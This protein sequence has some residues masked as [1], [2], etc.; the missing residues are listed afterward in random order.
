MA[1]VDSGKKLEQSMNIDLTDQCSC[2]S[3][4]PEDLGEQFAKPWALVVANMGAGFTEQR[5]NAY[6][7][8]YG[9]TA[10]RNFICRRHHGDGCHFCG[11]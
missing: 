5:R 3:R 1:R 10:F 8:S 7:F 4:R 6:V 2:I 9:F 11:L